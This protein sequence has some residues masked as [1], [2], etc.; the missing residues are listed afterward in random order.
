MGGR[1]QVREELRT[2]I[3]SILVT[4]Y[5]LFWCPVAFAMSVSFLLNLCT[6]PVFGF[7]LE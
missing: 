3:R 4:S 2:Q 5:T 6:F 1:C 7:S